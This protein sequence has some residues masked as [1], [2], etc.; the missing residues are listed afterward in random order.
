HVLRAAASTGLS[1]EEVT[2]RLRQLGFEISESPET[3]PTD[4]RIISRD[5]DGTAPW[6]DPQQP[7]PTTHVLRAAAS[8]GLS[9]EEVT[10]RLRQLGFEISESPEVNST[11]L[12]IIS[13][14]LDG[15]APWLSQDEPV[16]PDYIL[17]AARFTGRTP[18]EIAA[19]LTALNYKLPEFLSVEKGS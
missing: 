16:Y 12:Q 14:D 1:A 17:R 2:E 15:A 13:H 6:L 5:L 10:E 11:D 8:T 4:L 3:N 19:R 9:A 7:V 18:Y